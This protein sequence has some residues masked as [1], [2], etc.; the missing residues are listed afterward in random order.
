MA[1]SE[2]DLAPS[3]PLTIPAWMTMPAPSPTPRPP[4]LSRLL[5]TP[6]EM[7]A[8]FPTIMSRIASGFTIE[9]AL[10]EDH[11]EIDPGPFVAWMKRSKDRWRIYEE[12][13]EIRSEVWASRAIAHAAGDFLEDIERSKLQI[14]TLFRLMEAD[15]RKVY[16]KSQN[17]EVNQTVSITAALTAAQQ[18]SGLTLDHEPPDALPAPIGEDIP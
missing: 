9:K 5:L 16:G 10:V 4:T 11:R 6:V 2:T 13:K 7:E 15:N 18:R 3:Q 1:E 8:M 17:I 14:N 12:A